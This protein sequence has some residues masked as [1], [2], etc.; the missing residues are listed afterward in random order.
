MFLLYIWLAAL[1]A[2]L[3]AAVPIVLG[4]DTKA[5]AAGSNDWR[6]N[7]AIAAATCF[8]I[9]AAISA[10]LLYYLRGEVLH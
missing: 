9:A 3:V 8:A 2:V 4:R 10:G 7:L 1:G 5:V 6:L